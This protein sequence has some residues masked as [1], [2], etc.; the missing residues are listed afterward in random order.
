MGV[1]ANL[2][3]PKSG[4][5][6]IAATQACPR[7]P[8]LNSLQH[9]LFAWHHVGATVWTLPGASTPGTRGVRSQRLA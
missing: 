3:T 5:I 2:A 4:E 8:T 6:L 1:T 7:T 9:L